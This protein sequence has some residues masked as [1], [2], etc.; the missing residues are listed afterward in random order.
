MT[1]ESGRRRPRSTERMSQAARAKDLA[2]V[3]VLFAIVFWQ[4]VP[5]IT[6]ILGPLLPSTTADV[7]TCHPLLSCHRRTGTYRVAVRPD[8]SQCLCLASV[9]TPGPP[10]VTSGP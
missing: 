7:E 9:T 5:E 8:K 10:T 6:A 3:A 4:I 1:A 2:L